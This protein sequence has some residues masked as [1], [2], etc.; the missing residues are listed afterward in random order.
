[1]FTF[2]NTTMQPNNEK[3][4]NNKGEI[5]RRDFVALLQN[6]DIDAVMKNRFICRLVV[7]TFAAIAASESKEP[8]SGTRILQKYWSDESRNIRMV[9]RV[10]KTAKNEQ[11]AGV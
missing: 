2:K 1:M 3:Q 9:V 10:V 8:I 6:C 11:Q 4:C 7:K 5:L